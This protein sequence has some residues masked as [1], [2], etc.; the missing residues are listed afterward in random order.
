M[1]NSED[2]PRPGQPAG[3]DATPVVSRI[4]RAVEEDI[5][6]GRSKRGE[7]IVEAELAR[8]FEASRGPVREA[9]RHLAAQGLI[10]QHD[11]RGWAIRTM[12]QRD[13]RELYEVREVLEGQ[14]AALAAARCVDAD[15]R[16]QVVQLRDWLSQFENQLPRYVAELEDRDRF[17]D[18][19]AELADN[20]LLSSM[21]ERIRPLILQMQF[22]GFIFRTRP[23][24][25]LSEHIA[26]LDALLECDSKL[27]DE[28]T[29]AHIRSSRDVLLKLPADV[30]A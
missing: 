23:Q 6:A 26:I 19:L 15:V 10:E 16:G 25:S 20:T 30:F 24:E 22:R 4:V 11:R 18:E 29:R 7:R 28:L 8:R 21:L 13:V 14:A 1:T 5:A 27:A 2:H 17:H 9:L 3:Y 12:S